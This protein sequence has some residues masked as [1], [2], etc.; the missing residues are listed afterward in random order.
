MSTTAPKMTATEA[1]HFETYSAANATAV[2]LNL[3][4]DCQPYEDVFTY[5]RWR[6]LGYQVKA[7]EKAIRIP[8]IKTVTQEDDH[9]ETTTRRIKKTS[10]VFCR[11]QVKPIEKS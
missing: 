4:C 11:C 7:G 10:C 5:A 2:L 3:D 1:A 6:A 9:G 8:T